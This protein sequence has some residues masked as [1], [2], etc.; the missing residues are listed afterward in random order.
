MRTPFAIRAYLAVTTWLRR[1]RGA[2]TTEYALLLALVVVFLIS[3]LGQLG[4]ALK[5]K[6][7]DIIGQITGV[8]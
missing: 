2:A 4:Q 8:N 6:L 1:E 7:L 5:N 3:T